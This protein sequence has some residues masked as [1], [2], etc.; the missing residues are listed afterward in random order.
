MGIS[1]LGFAIIGV[2]DATWTNARVAAESHIR[3]LDSAVV[4]ETRFRLQ[5]TGFSSCPHID[6]SYEQALSHPHT[7]GRNAFT[8]NVVRYEYWNEESM[9]WVDFGTSTRL[10]CAA[11]DDLA[12]EF[13]VQR[14][15]VSMSSISQVS[16][17][18]SF[19]KT[20]GTA[21]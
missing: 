14:I 21:L 10:Q 15:T 5:Q 12:D 7:R 1:L 20:R 4:A 16:S 6:L 3:S 2:L 19:V 9:T 11:L 13:A 18:A 8:V 17:T